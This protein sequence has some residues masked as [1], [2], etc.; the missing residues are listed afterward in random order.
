MRNLASSYTMRKDGVLPRG[1]WF[2]F[3]NKADETP[4]IYIY[5]EIGFWGTE[6]SEFVKQLNELTDPKIELHLNSPG[7][8][9]FDGLAIYNA[10]KQ[11]SAEIEIYVDGLAASAASFIAQ[12]GDK[13]IMARNA[14][15]MIHD[16]IAF[17]YG[18]E[19][20][21]LATAKLLSQLSNNIADIYGQAAKR[22]GVSMTM[23]GFRD[24]MREEV[25]Y[26]GT[27][28]VEAGLADDVLDKDDEE[29]DKATNKW[30]LSFYNYAGRD[31][32]E[33]PLRIQEKIRLE[34]R[35]K[36]TDM[37]DKAPNNTVD[38]EVTPAPAPDTT[39]PTEPATDPAPAA[40]ESDPAPAPAEPAAPA[41]AAPAPTTGPENKGTQGVLINGVLTTDWNVINQ[42]FAAL[43][44]AQAEQTQ[45][46]RKNF[47]ESL[48]ASNK[49]PATQIDGLVA[50]VNGDGENVPAMSDEQFAAFK[51]SYESLPVSTL[52]STVPAAT[53][54]D[55]TNPQNSGFSFDSPV[56]TAEQKKDR[57]AVLEGT[58]AMH[59]RNMNAED[60]KSTKSYIELQELLG[61]ENKS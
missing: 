59:S 26:N 6:A 19:E 30:D 3:V 23:E 58:V 54:N 39:P 7:G 45:V 28:T 31:K 50:L 57:I 4:K 42:H 25:W 43:N 56:M 34:N 11:H 61:A 16:G 12:A 21:M 5:D 13:V 33:S 35:Q 36:G 32:A 49:I 20:D 47:V 18:N 8:E 15:M 51:A 2:S 46:H 53:Q 60:V 37:G 1:D 17:A 14:Q 9:I 29:A 48:G 38:P 24:L 22:R 44:T 52:F 41:P 10:L 27:E 55:Q 40:P